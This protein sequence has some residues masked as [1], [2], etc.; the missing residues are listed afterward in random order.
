M[1]YFEDFLNEEIEISPDNQDKKIIPGINIKSEVQKKSTLTKKKNSV[2]IPNGYFLM[3][4]PENLDDLTIGKLRTLHADI[5]G[6]EPRHNSAHNKI[7][8]ANKIK[9]ILSE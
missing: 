8:I 4:I 2:K 1:S 7:W 6:K 5:F 3:K 9:G